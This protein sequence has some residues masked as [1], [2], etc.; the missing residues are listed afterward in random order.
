VLSE[1]LITPCRFNILALMAP[2]LS[3]LSIGFSVSPRARYALGVNKEQGWFLARCP[4][5]NILALFKVMIVLLATLRRINYFGHLRQLIYV[6]YSRIY[7]KAAKTNITSLSPLVS[8]RM[9][10]MSTGDL[11]RRWATKKVIGNRTHISDR[12]ALAWWC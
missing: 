7:F 11:L 12:S 3:E 10:A 2:P 5:S 1:E 8:G 9:Q 4:L 6:R